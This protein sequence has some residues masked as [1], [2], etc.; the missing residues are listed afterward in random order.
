M[1][2]AARRSVLQRPRVPPGIDRQANR[3]PAPTE[4]NHHMRKVTLAALAASAAFLAGPAMAQ[5]NVDWSKVEVTT[6]DLGHNTY[7]LSTGV[8]GNITFAVGTDGIIVVDANFAPAYEKFKAAIQKVSTLPV[9]YVI[10]THFHGDHTGG[11]ALFKKDGAT[12]VA[13]DNIR[14]RLLGG[15][16]NGVTGNKTPPVSSPD[17][18]PT[19]TYYGGT[20]EIEVGGR[21]AILTH[22]YNAHTDGDSYVYF[23]DANVLCTGDTFNNTKRYQ[24]VDFANGGDIRGMV[25]AN[26][27]YFDL[28][29]NDTKIVPGHG[30]LANKA[31]VAA[32]RDM[33]TTARD[34]L[35]KLFQ[36]GK[37]VDEV[38]AM[39]PLKDL[40]AKW[41]VDDNAAKN[42]TLQYYRSFTR[43]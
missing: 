37:S 29:N 42:F 23:P 24:T 25:R 39:R 30:G 8:G 2:P 13:E 12:I 14:L 43:S 18:L 15:T 31:D 9:K 1:V 5:Q 27:A 7:M 19:D 40:D 20:K 10:N 35:Q 28:A 17:A 21:K 36:E 22:V 38:V 3:R 11:N 32:F 41:A 33:L 4:E 6:T 16:I 34:R 26:T